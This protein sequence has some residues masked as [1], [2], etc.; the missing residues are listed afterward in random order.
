MA[1]RLTTRRARA[2]RHSGEPDAAPRCRRPRRT[3]RPPPAAAAPVAPEHVLLETPPPPPPP[4]KWKEGDKVIARWHLGCHYPGTIEAVKPNGVYAVAFDDGDYD[5]NVIENHIRAAPAPA[6]PPPGSRITVRFSDGIDYGGTITELVDEHHARVLY[7]DGQ[8]ETVRFPDPDVRVLRAAPVARAGDD[9]ED[10]EGSRVGGGAI[11]NATGRACL[12]VEKKTRL[13]YRKLPIRTRTT[14]AARTNASRG[15]R[16]QLAAG[17]DHLLDAAPQAPAARPAP[18][19][20]DE[21]APAPAP[22]DNDAQQVAALEKLHEVLKDKP[23]L[24]VCRKPLEDFGFR[25]GP[26]SRWGQMDAYPPQSLPSIEDIIG[27]KYTWTN[28]LNSV[29]KCIAYLEG[30]LNRLSGGRLFPS[31]SAPKKKRAAIA[32]GEAPAPTITERARPRWS[33]DEERRLR[34]LVAELGETRWPA[35]AMRLGT[36]RTG[37]AV[38][39]RWATLK[40]K[41]PEAATRRGADVRPGRR[42]PHHHG[43]RARRRRRTAKS[44][45]LVEGAPRRREQTVRSARARRAARRPGPRRRAQI[46]DAGAGRRRLGSGPARAGRRRGRRSDRASFRAAAT[47]TT[48]RT[49]A[50]PSSRRHSRKRS[51]RRSRRRAAGRSSGFC[52]G[53][54]QR[55]R[56]APRV[57]RAH[58]GAV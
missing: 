34:D 54:A 44:G 38:E 7:D 28:S 49:P 14:R 39:L 51:R 47:T 37:A 16:P 23:N 25:C 58:G 2:P 36:G 57:R 19:P 42:R 12:V 26:L 6:L 17:Q 41:S 18:A 55:A 5:D 56:V 10:A 3:P 32:A 43:R 30:V 11:D 40:Q 21:P 45:G 46:D 4:S 24:T 20:T 27:D 50:S 48:T 9:D 13:V 15:R 8:S 31:P 33:S 52:H 1:T 53:P 22:G 29:P 35:I